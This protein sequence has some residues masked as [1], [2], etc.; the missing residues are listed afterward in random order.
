MRE[1]LLGTYS[2]VWKNTTR[3][4]LIQLT[5]IEVTL[6]RIPKFYS[7]V[8]RKA[9]L[10]GQVHPA[11]IKDQ[12]QIQPINLIVKQQAH[13]AEDVTQQQIH[14]VREV[15]SHLIGTAHLCSGENGV[16]KEVIEG[17]VR[18]EEAM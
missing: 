16:K 7:R 11:P 18:L 13:P 6:K 1:A 12:K 15:K 9:V 4:T 10:V 5:Y 3:F 17:Q 14:H 2:H 8:A